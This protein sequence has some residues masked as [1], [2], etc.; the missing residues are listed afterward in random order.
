MAKKSWLDSLAEH[1]AKKS[2]PKKVAAPVS[3][4]TPPQEFHIII[5]N[6]D[7]QK[8]DPGEI[9]VAFF[10]VQDS[11]V[12]LTDEH[13]RQLKDSRTEVLPP[14][15][16]PL[17]IARGLLRRRRS[18]SNSTFDRPLPNNWRVPC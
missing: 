1:G 6:A 16:D 13:G 10:V 9:A 3:P 17:L 7:I 5:R 14:S 8:N 12:K 18:E 2:K 15:T 11:V 4:A